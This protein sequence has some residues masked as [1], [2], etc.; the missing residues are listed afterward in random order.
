MAGNSEDICILLP[1]MLYHYSISRYFF[2]EYSLNGRI[3]E[4]IRLLAAD[5]AFHGNRIAVSDREEL[6]DI[7]PL[8]M[9]ADAIKADT[10]SGDILFFDVMIPPV[11]YGVQRVSTIHVGCHTYAGTAS[12][13]RIFFH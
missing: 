2:L 3:I 7:I 9:N 6:F 13:I 4:K 8:M 5:D 10:T 1:A 12:S 11:R